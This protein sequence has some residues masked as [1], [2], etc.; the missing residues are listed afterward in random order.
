MNYTD[1]H[2]CP[3][4]GVDYINH[5][6]LILT[7]EELEKS[8]LTIKKLKKQLSGL[9]NKNKMILKTMNDQII[10]IQQDYKREVKKM[11]KL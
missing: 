11:G 1:K 7:C 3:F 2:F 10:D 4:C 6:G 9:R 5:N 8:K